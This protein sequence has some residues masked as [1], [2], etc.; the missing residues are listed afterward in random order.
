MLPLHAARRGVSTCSFLLH[1]L[2]EAAAHRAG[3]LPCEAVRG[4]RLI[5]HRIAAC[6]RCR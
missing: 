3:H 2:L 4:R 6:L 5:R 1:V